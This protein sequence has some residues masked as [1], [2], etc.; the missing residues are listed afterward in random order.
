MSKL[1][2]LGGVK[3]AERVAADLLDEFGT[4]RRALNGDPNRIR[5]CA[6]ATTSA[7]I[8][9]YRDAVL[10]A[11]RPEPGRPR[12]ASRQALD[13]YLTFDMADRKLE[14]CRVFYLD[15][16][17]SLLRE[18]IAAFGSTS[19][20]PLYI[21][22][23]ITRAIELGATGLILVHNHPAGDPTPS[24]ADFRMTRR[25]A[26]TAKDLDIRLVEHLIVSSAGSYSWREHGLL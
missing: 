16:D 13:A 18:E 7:A 11:L 19:E 3:E 6:D 8:A 5:R 12:L 9:F 10:Q 17:V 25:L 22:R 4:L 26:R 21:R 24:E 23:I 1:L 2:T 15:F 14:E 20:C